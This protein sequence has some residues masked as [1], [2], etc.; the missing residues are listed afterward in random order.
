MS[1]GSPLSHRT[2]MPRHR[3]SQNMGHR[4]D[5]LGNRHLGHQGLIVLARG[6]SPHGAELQHIVAAPAHHFGI[7]MQI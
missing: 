4:R 7:D 5:A 1:Q 3:I 6:A 2:V